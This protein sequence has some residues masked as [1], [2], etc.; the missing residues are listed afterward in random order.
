M[1]DLPAG[2]KVL[3]RAIT[4]ADTAL[5]VRW[6]NQESVKKHLFSQEE[7]TPEQHLQYLRT[8][9]LTGQTAQFI[10][11]VQETQEP[12]GTV[13]LK[14]IDTHAQK[15]EFGIFI[16]ADSARGKGCGQEAASLILRYGFE[17]LHLHRI[18][19]SVFSDN[20]PAIASYQKAGFLREGILRQDFKRD[21]GYVDVLVMGILIGEWSARNHQVTQN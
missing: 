15:A 4:E 6:R 19:L 21:D 13:F 2:N 9:V 10:I 14:N 12:I 17:R 18:W 1:H 20:L 16:G 11:V 5:I 3:L 8:R 7:L